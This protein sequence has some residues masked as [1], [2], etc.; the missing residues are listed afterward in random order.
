M[1]S[2]PHCPTNVFLFIFPEKLSQK[3]CLKEQ[4]SQLAVVRSASFPAVLA[5]G[6]F[7]AGLVLG[8]LCT[9]RKPQV[10]VSLQPFS[11]A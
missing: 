1:G 11:R 3:N 6:F 8:V 4:L 5:A 10:S 2:P 9:L 7:L